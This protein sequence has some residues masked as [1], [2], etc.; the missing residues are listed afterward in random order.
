MPLLDRNPQKLSYSLGSTGRLYI[1]VCMS[2]IAFT[3]FGQW[4]FGGA[5]F[6]SAKKESNDGYKWSI[7]CL[8]MGAIGAGLTGLK[9]VDRTEDRNP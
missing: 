4:L 3:S 6:E 5:V 1:L 2:L 8:S 7:I 9:F